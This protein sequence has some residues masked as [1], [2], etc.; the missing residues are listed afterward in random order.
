MDFAVITRASLILADDAL[1]QR[2][3]RGGKLAYS[4]VVTFIE[5]LCEAAPQFAA[6]TYAFAYTWSDA[7]QS[8]VVIFSS[9][10]SLSLLSVFKG[11][12]TF[13]FYRKEIMKVLGSGS[14]TPF[15]EALARVN[16]TRND[17]RKLSVID[18]SRK[19]LS[20]EEVRWIARELACGSLRKVT[21]LKYVTTP[22]ACR[23]VLAFAQKCQRPPLDVSFWL[24]LAV[25]TATA[26]VMRAPST[27]PRR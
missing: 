19:E 23:F 1:N 18:W 12:I 3:H 15:D 6:Q 13:I 25:S 2:S 8:D 21:S 22:L 11:V 16:L 14:V 17:A 7:S 4:R 9:S 24:S 20:D 5:S 10:A 27:S 26:S